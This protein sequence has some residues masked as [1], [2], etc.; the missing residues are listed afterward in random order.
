MQ[1]VGEDL[2]FL[3]FAPASEIAGQQ[4]EIGAIGQV[5]E[6]W[7]EDSLRSL[8]VVQVTNRRDSDQETGSSS[9]GSLAGT[10]VVSLTI[11]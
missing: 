2:D 1:F 10:T 11:S 4:Q 7:P 8:A 9:S 6:A 5:L 3:R